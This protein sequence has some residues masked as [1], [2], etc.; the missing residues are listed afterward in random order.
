MK[1]STIT[2]S[3]G[4]NDPLDWKEPILEAKSLIAEG[5]SI[6]WYLDCGLSRGKLI[7][8]DEL[9]WNAID[10]AIRQ[11]TEVVLPDFQT[12][13]MGVCLYQ[14]YADIAER[15]VWQPQDAIFFDEFMQEHRMRDKAAKILFSWNVFADYLQRIL[16]LLPD[17]MTIFANFDIE[18][19]LNPEMVPIIFSKERFPHLILDLKSTLREN[20]SLAEPISLG[21]ALPQD[22]RM[23]EEMLIMINDIE[24]MLSLKKIL[25]RV[26]PEAE[27]HLE[28]EGIEALIYFSEN[29]D[30]IGK[31]GITGFNASGGTLIYADAPLGFDDETDLQSWIERDRS[32]GIRT[33]DLLLPK[34]PR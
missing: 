9:Y 20:H 21:I 15:F 13:S 4:P 2:L 23:S 10:L 5:R 8:R 28:W 1:T 30:R 24:K 22:G 25:F 11:F 33:P 6:L 16:V 29:I 12:T 18:V 34:Q 14:G 32:R 27:L 31:R 7:L 19:G 26:I 17:T 3:C